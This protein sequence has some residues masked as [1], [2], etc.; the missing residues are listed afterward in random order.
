MQEQIDR[1]KKTAM[2]VFSE[3]NA[4]YGPSWLFFRFSSTVDQL[5]IK[6]LRIRSLEEH[7]GVTAVGEGCEGEYFGLINYAIIALMQREAANALPTPAAALE[8]LTLL[9]RIDEKLLLSLYDAAFEQARSLM[10]LKNSDYSDAWRKIELSS[11][12]DLI[13]VKLVRMKHILHT[14]EE[15][16]VSEGI[17]SQLCDIINYAIF[18]LIRLEQGE[19]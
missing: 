14:G 5:W 10:Q 3:K 15:L 1:I 12:T 8:D 18:A 4:D 19:E 16:R 13:L 7:G 6:I 11:I 2:Q 9:Q 17:E